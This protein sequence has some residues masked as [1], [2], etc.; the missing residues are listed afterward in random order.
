MSIDREMDKDGGVHIYSGILLSHK[1]EQ[2]CAIYRNVDM[3]WDCHRE[4]S[5][6][7]RGK[8]IVYS[9]IYKWSLKKFYRWTYLQSRNR[10]IDAENKC[11]DVKGRRRRGWI[12]RFGIDIYTL[13][14]IKLIINEGLLYITG[15]SI[16]CSVVT[17]M[18]KEFKNRGN[19]C[20]QR[21]DSLH[22]TAEMNTTL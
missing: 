16:L 15:N 8:Q 13:L 18:G 6:S 9:I 4:W 11:M 5:K 10:E 12:G 7:E 21:A 22:S 17:K 14:C 2:N 19:I 1:N 20:I 3:P